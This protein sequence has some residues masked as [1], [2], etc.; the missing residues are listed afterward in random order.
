[1]LLPSSL[2]E[3]GVLE[4]FF[5]LFSCMFNSVYVCIP[6]EGWGQIEWN[7][8]V[9]GIKISLYSALQWNDLGFIC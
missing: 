7:D 4:S 5:T 3:F 9:V 1:M 6:A 8:S 2:G